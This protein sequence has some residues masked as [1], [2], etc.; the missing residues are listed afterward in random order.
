M[1][2]V[3]HTID[4][5]GPGGAETVFVSLVKGVDKCLYQ[6]IAAINGPGWVYGE[7]LK[8]GVEPFFLH[9]EGGFNIRY[10]I[11]LIKTIRNNKVDIVHSH[12]FGS[13]VYCSLA[14]LI[15]RVPVVSTFHGFVDTSKQDILWYIKTKIINHG[16]QCI[17]FVSE[18]LKKTFVEKYG[19][20]RKKS[21]SIVNGVDTTIFRPERDISLRRDLN[22]ASENI[23]VGAIGNIRQAKG[24]EVFIQAAKLMVARDSRYRFVIV[25]EGSGVL[26]SKLVELRDNLGLRGYVYFLGF[27]DDIPRILNNLDAFVLSSV[28]EGFSISTIQAMACGVPVVITRS[29]GPEEIVANTKAQVVD[30]NDPEG[31]A[32]A[33]ERV[34]TDNEIR[35]ESVSLGLTT[36]LNKY[37]LSSVLQQY[38][39]VYMGLGRL[40]G[41]RGKG[42]IPPHRG[43]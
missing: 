5:T 21:I 27:R 1:L 11:G 15:C 40:G 2:R 28:S 38:E 23:L 13:N 3:L 37:S 32:L 22:L 34:M 30:V 31:I 26:Y 20:S 17:V 10:L 41:I 14:G 7:L 36:V 6:S 39:S 42:T 19:F 12:L 16:S 24:Y 29:G 9:S 33:L 8:S 18:H 43:T 25:G 4:T 35:E